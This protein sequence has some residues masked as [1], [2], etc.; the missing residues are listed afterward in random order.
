MVGIQKSRQAFPKID[1][2]G[3]KP[4]KLLSN[5]TDKDLQSSG[6]AH[7]TIRHNLAQA[8]RDTGLKYPLNEMEGKLHK[9]RK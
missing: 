7:N 6:K 4:K 9:S 5:M 3:F 2:D 1:P 8:D